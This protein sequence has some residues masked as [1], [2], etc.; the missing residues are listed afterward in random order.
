V[1]LTFHLD[2]ASAAATGSDAAVGKLGWA[3]ELADLA[4]D[5]QGHRRP[6]ASRP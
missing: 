4:L 3:R 2:A 6:A 1:S 5:E